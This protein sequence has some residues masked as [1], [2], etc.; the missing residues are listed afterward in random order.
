MTALGIEL[1]RGLAQATLRKTAQVGL[2]NA[3]ANLPYIKKTILDLERNPGTGPTSAVVFGGG[4]SLHR[5]NPAR[6]LRELG[7][8]GEAV[9]SDAALGYCLRNGLVPQYV[10]T[11]DSHPYRIVRWF[12]DPLFDSRPSDDYFLR[13]DLDPFHKDESRANELTLELV[14]AHGKHIKAIIATSVDPGVTRRCLEAGMELYWW[15]PLYDDYDAPHSHSRRVQELT[16]VPCM[17]M[18]G[19]VGS[20]AFVFAAAV[21]RASKVALVGFDMSY[22]PGTPPLNTQYYYQLRELLGDRIAE[23]FIEIETPHTGETW[24]SDP[25]YYWYRQIFLEI[26]AVAECETFNCTEGGVLF[27]DDVRFVALR[28]FLEKYGR[29][30]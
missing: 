7:Y 9:G 17:V 21:L 27:G 26:A 12:G 4:P 29:E 22:A 6:T 24:I 3:E 11:V 5:K 13:Q 25:T 8:Q 2:A 20:S 1:A 15:N 19:N 16:N 30:K 14:N 18:G 28:D 10:V 23:A